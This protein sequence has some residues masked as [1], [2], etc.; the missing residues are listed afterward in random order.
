MEA[1]RC[2]LYSSC[3]HYTSN[4]GEDT[5]NYRRSLKNCLG[6]SFLQRVNSYC[7]V[8]PTVQIGSAATGSNHTKLSF[9]SS[10]TNLEAIYS[11]L[12]FQ[13]SHLIL[14]FSLSLHSSVLSKVN[15]ASILSSRLQVRK[16]NPQCSLNPT[17]FHQQPSRSNTCVL[18]DVKNFCWICS[19]FLCV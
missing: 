16:Y 7:I 13:S 8:S 19:L 12:I 4:Q 14:T 6:K 10:N 1:H 9:K 15:F 2:H 11:N 17:S 3:I 5:A 18:T